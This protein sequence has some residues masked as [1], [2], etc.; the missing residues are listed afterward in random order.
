MIFKLAL[1]NLLRRRTQS[2]LAAGAVAGGLALIIFTTNF[3]DGSW[4]GVVDDTIRAAAGHVVVQANGYQEEQDADLLLP[5]SSALAGQVR[6]AAP[7]AHVVRRLFLQGMVASPDNAVAVALHGIEPKP[8]AKTSRMAQKL[9]EGRWLPDD[10]GAWLLI[11]HRLAKRLNV[12]VDDKVVVSISHRGEIQGLPF[13]IAGIF[14]TGAPQLDNFLALASLSAAQS[15]LPG[16]EDPAT[17]VSV[18][19]PEFEAEPS[20]LPT[21]RQAIGAD[22]EVLTWQ[23]ALPDLYNAELL[24]KKSSKIMWFFFAALAS[25]GILNVLLMSLFQRIREF[26]ML[27]AL[28]MRPNDIVRLL[29]A[30]GFLLG[31]FGSLGGLL[32]GCAA[33][34][35]LVVVGIDFAAMQGSVPISNVAI[36]TLIKGVWSWDKMFLWAGYHVALSLVASL[37]PALRASRLEPVESLRAT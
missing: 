35:P 17:Q 24:D 4:R 26:G 2:L 12:G 19:V 29:L 34:Y 37:W 14:E 16:I 31:L 1:R 5:G 25:I 30:E 6:S 15:M 7:H 21:V 11:G 23:E 10:D 3:Q 22:H 8:E 9:K 28:G 18:Q 33:T 36:D 13:R 32:M 20:L 27:Q